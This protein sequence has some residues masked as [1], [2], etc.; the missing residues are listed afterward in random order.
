MARILEERST[1]INVENSAEYH[2]MQLE[3]EKQKQEETKD[4]A[5]EQHLLGMEDLAA[6]QFEDLMDE[7][8]KYFLI[9]MNK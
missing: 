6:H 7:A 2:Q 1:H 8:S 5:F 3:F 4:E 9:S